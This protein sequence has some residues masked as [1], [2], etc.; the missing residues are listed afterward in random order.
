MALSCVNV[1]QLAV[2]VIGAM[3]LN[4]CSTVPQLPIWLIVQASCTILWHFLVNTLRFRTR[5]ESLAARFISEAVGIVALLGFFIAHFVF[6]FFG[7]ERPMTQTR[8]FYP[9]A[10]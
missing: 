8:F 2:F 10:T 7:E 1:I 4:K 6:M 5:L 3:K 9:S